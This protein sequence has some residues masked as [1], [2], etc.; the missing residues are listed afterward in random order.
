[1]VQILNAD[2]GYRVTPE[3]EWTFDKSAPYGELGVCAPW[4]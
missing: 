3:T 1:M 2:C 4:T